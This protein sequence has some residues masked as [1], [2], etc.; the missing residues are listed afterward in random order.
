MDYKE[1][2]LL[3]SKQYVRDIDEY[4]EILDNLLELVELN[5]LHDEPEYKRI[6]E[7]FLEQ[8]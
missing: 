1:R 3:L 5:G 4:H 8:D 2:Y 6:K 7:W